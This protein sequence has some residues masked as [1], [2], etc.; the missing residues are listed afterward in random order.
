[1]YEALHYAADGSLLDAKR[2]RWVRV[3]PWVPKDEVVQLIANGTDH[4]VERCLSRPVRGRRERFQRDIR[5]DLANEPV[6]D[7][8][9]AGFVAELWQGPAST[10]LLFVEQALQPRSKDELTDQA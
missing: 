9:E 1:M 3:R 5:S 8:S 10:V 2:H 6:D 7:L 4:L